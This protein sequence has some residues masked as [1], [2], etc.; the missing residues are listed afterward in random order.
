MHAEQQAQRQAP[1][2]AKPEK[3][4]PRPLDHYRMRE[5]LNY[6]RLS[7]ADKALV[8]KY[9]KSSEWG[10][11]LIRCVNLIHD[12]FGGEGIGPMVMPP[13][14]WPFM[15]KLRGLKPA[16]FR[17]PDLEP[18]QEDPITHQAPKPQRPVVLGLEFFTAGNRIEYERISDGDKAILG[19]WMKSCPEGAEIM[20]RIQ[21]RVQRQIEATGQAESIG[22]ITVPFS[23]WNWLYEERKRLRAIEREAAA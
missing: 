17:K 4:P 11:D 10:R 8:G 22:Y 16:P 23:F 13:D 21:E 14:F 9:F 7:D 20:E 18:V 15:D 12:A 2:P 5:K 1:T 6:A 19:R 3:A